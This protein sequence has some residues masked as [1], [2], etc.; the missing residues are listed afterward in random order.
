MSTCLSFLCQV[1]YSLVYVCMY[2]C[3]VVVGR[4]VCMYNRIQHQYILYLTTA[5]SCLSVRVSVR[6][7]VCTYVCMYVCVYVCMV[8]IGTE[9]KGVVNLQQQLASM[10]PARPKESEEDSMNKD[11]AVSPATRLVND[12]VRIVYVCMYVCMYVT[13]CM[14]ICIYSSISLHV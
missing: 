6:M 11:A 2:V 12:C 8:S 5:H 3:R 1:S 13:V 9:R 14:C 4:Y 7:Y 10:V